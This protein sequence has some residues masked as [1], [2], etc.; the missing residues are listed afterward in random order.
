[1]D[2]ESPSSCQELPKFAAD[3][4][5]LNLQINSEG[6]LEC[7]GRIEGRYPVYL[8]DDCLFTEKFVQRSHRRTLH[9]GVALT[10][11]DIWERHW[12]P[13]LR[14]IMKKIIKSC[15]RC[16]RFQAI[17]ISSPP[18]GLLP[19]E[20]TAGS[21][22]FEVVGV[23]FA[24]PI[25]Y[26]RSAPEEGKAYLVL[27]ACR[28]SRA[29]HLEILP[30]LET[31]TFLGSLKRLIARRGRPSSIYSDNGRTVIGAAKWFKQIRK[32]ERIQSFLADEEV[33]WRFNLNPTQR[34]QVVRA[35]DLKSVG[36][37]FKSRSDR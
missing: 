25:K 28:L 20:R 22:A 1:M 34:G 13:R 29:L 35:P 17:A 32:D 14:Q 8:S 26:R 19:R 4:M 11:A 31:A 18:P 30:N 12:V 3:R 37:G 23:D 15:W 9:G 5:Q 7:Q 16:K 10:T 21:N 36:R 33:H 6:I 24:G 2:P 27:F